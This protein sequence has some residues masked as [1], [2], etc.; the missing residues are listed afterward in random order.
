[1]LEGDPFEKK[2]I[3]T[4]LLAHE[5]PVALFFHNFTPALTSGTPT[6]KHFWK[7]GCFSCYVRNQIIAY[8]NGRFTI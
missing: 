2:S 1:M 6:K 3:Q 7:I 5:I 4:T 8:K